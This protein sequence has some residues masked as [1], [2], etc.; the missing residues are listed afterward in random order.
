MWLIIKANIRCQ[1]IQ[2][3]NVDKLF[4]RALKGLFIMRHIYGKVLDKTYGG[5]ASF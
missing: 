5:S 1:I 3:N 2:S 4:L